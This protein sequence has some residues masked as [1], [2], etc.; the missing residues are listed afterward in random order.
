MNYAELEEIIKKKEYDKLTPEHL[1]NIL[2]VCQTCKESKTLDNYPK[3]KECRYGHSSSCKP[4][5]NNKYYKK[6]R[7]PAET[8]IRKPQ[9]TNELKNNNLEINK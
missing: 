2:R 8:I 3:N 7:I 4:C 9:E 6:K 1:K 5:F